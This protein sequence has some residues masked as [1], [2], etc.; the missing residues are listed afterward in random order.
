MQNAALGLILIGF[1]LSSFREPK[2]FLLLPI[3]AAAPAQSNAPQ[4]DASARKSVEILAGCVFL[5]IGSAGGAP[6]SLAVATGAAAVAMT[7]ERI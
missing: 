6:C 5:E 3:G 7:W 4:E 1:A 2:V